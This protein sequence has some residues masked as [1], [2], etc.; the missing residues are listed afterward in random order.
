MSAFEQKFTAFLSTLKTTGV[1]LGDDVIAKIKTALQEVKFDQV[2]AVTPV[3]VAKKKLNGYNLFMK[4]R[5]LKL[6]ESDLDSNAR[7][8]QISNE[9]KALKE[10]ERESWKQKAKDLVPAEKLPIK[11]KKQKVTKL[12]AY[13]V[14]VREQMVELKDLKPKERMTTIGT[15]WKALPEAKK[16]EY[17]V[18]ATAENEKAKPSA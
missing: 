5:M 18:K 10:E 11:L 7:M 3:V 12:S 4:D 9:W 2:G 6:K 16:E 1:S 17:K 14:F 13:Q 8:T 15:R